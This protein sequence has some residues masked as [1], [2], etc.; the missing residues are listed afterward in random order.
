MARKAGRNFGKRKPPSAKTGETAPAS[1]RS[2]QVALVLMGALAIGG[3]AYALMPS[4][5]KCDPSDPNLTPEQ[6]AACRSEQS[7]SGSSHSWRA[8]RSSF[9]NRHA[10]G[11]NAAGHSSA[12]HASSGLA[13]PTFHG[14]TGQTSRGGFGG[15]G[16]AIASHFS[17]GG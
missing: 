16:H 2:G 8:S 15:F 5:K 4:G 6:R 1:K 14:R 9:F 11:G 13:V 10:Y 3:G 17:R 12:G 7:S